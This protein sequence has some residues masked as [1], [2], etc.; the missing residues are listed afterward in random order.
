MTRTGSESR[1]GGLEAAVLD[2]GGGVIRSEGD[3][4]D[5]IEKADMVVGAGTWAR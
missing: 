1:T 2:G 4:L 5:E 3:G